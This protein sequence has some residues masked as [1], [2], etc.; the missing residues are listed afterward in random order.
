MARDLRGRAATAS[1]SVSRCTT[2]RGFI[3]RISSLL[4][5]HGRWLHSASTTGWKSPGHSEDRS[6]QVAR[7]AGLRERNTGFIGVV[8]V[9]AG[10]PRGSPARIY[11]CPSLG[12]GSSPA[13]AEPHGASGQEQ[14]RFSP[15]PA[16]V[17]I[18][19]R[20]FRSEHPG[21]PLCPPLPP[22]VTPAISPAHFRTTSG[23]RRQAGGTTTARIQ[24]L[25][26]PADAAG[27]RCLAQH[28]PAR[29]VVIADPVGNS[30]YTS[31]RLVT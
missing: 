21:P 18:A 22:P 23:R 29:F 4:H 14:R 26:I 25:D 10:R 6:V 24:A 5:C 11:P 13:R 19:H 15:A 28:C 2:I 9:T 27:L 7:L 17:S 31:V 12:A 20:R 30:V 1:W 8:L 16:P 3:Q